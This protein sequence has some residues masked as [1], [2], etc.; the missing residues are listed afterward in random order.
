MESLNKKSR[1]EQAVHTKKILLNKAFYLIE[2]NGYDNVTIDQICNE[3][4][5]TKG[6]FYHHFKSKADI[7]KKRFKIAEGDILERYNSNLSLPPNEQLRCI[8]DFYVEYFQLDRLDEVKVFHK[9]Q[10]DNHYKNFAVTSVFQRSVLTNIIRAGQRDGYFNKDLDC[11]ETAKFIMT[12][13]YGLLMEWCAY[14]GKLDFAASL[15]NFYDNY[16]TKLLIP[17]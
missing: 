3:L 1:V 11:V 12:Y 5:L 10:L 9:I 16:L 15:N 7:L 2:K 17:K 14:D 6:A 8:F 13:L 4:G